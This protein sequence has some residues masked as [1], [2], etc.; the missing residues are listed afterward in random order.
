MWWL[1]L[2]TT[3]PL[4]F[5]SLTS[6][7]GTL[8]ELAD[9]L[10]DPS[11][12]V[13]DLDW[14]RSFWHGPLI[15]KGIQ[16]VDDARRV[17]DAGAD[18]IVLSNH[19]GRQLECAPV[20]LR[21]VPDVVDAVGDR[22]EVWVDS[23]IMLAQTWSRRLRWAPARPWSGVPICTGSWPGASEGSSGRQRFLPARFAGPCSSSASGRSAS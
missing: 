8:G 6:S 15:I 7:E 11:M 23:G 1:N 17:V 10:F 16:T 5:A 3:S 9:K 14:L 21:L 20:P 18:A 19:G 22:T 13:A 12:T 4:T 2:L